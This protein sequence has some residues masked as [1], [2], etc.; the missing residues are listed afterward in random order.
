[1]LVAGTGASLNP[2]PLK[3]V[4]GVVVGPG[5]SMVAGA[6]VAIDTGVAGIHESG[7]G[8]RMDDVTLPLT[9]MLAHPRAAGVSLELLLRAIRARATGGG[10]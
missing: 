1:V 3:S 2:L 8:Y 10:R 5:A 6:R 9:S 4:P 7:T